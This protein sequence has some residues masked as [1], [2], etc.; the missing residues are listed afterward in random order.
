MRVSAPLNDST[1]AVLADWVELQ[2]LLLEGPVAEQQLIRSQAAQ[3]EPDHGDVLTE[4]DLEVADEEI[5]ETSA[6]E[7]S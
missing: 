7:L 6:D 3:S 1:R 2:A 5:L 4:L